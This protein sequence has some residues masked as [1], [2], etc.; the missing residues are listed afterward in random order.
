MWAEPDDM[1]AM[2]ATKGAQRTALALA[3]TLSPTLTLTL[4]LTLRTVTLT[5]YCP[6]HPTHTL[7]TPYAHDQARS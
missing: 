6:N 7:R 3:L 5:L 2:L 4:T 1:A